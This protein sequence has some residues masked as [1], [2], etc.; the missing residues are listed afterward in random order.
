[1]RLIVCVCDYWQRRH[2]YNRPQAK[3]IQIESAD[4]GKQLAKHKLMR[5]LSV[6][7]DAVSGNYLLREVLQQ[8]VLQH[9]LQHNLSVQLLWLSLQPPARL[10]ID[11]KWTLMLSH[12]IAEHV[13][14]DQLMCWL[15]TLG[16]GY[17][18]LGD[19][20]TRCAEAAG[21]ISLQQLSIGLRLGNPLLQARCK[22]YYSISLIQRGELRQAKQLIRNQYR[23]ACEQNDQRLKRMCHGV[24]ERLRYEYGERQRKA[25]K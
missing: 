21:K 6:Q 23:L 4:E 15:S 3:D 18:S 5:R 13:Q 8:N 1:M 11:Y 2:Y 16:G 17:S 14:L 9:Q 25:I 24:W 12:T 22:L 10:G 19:Q 20:F 7:L